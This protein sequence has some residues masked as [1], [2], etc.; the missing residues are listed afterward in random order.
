MVPG[1]ILAGVL[2]TGAAVG[3]VGAGVGLGVAAA[4]RI[5]AAYG[6]TVEQMQAQ[7]QQQEA[8]YYDQP[9]YSGYPGSFGHY[10]HHSSRHYPSRRSYGYH[11]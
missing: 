7:Q 9:A 2:L 6:A 10:S 4:H 5:G 1:A 3:V 8:Y 11:Y